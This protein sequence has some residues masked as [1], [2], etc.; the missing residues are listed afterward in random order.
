[1]NGSLSALDSTLLKQQILLEAATSPKIYA[2]VLSCLPQSGEIGQLL[3]RAKADH[4][5]VLLHR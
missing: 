5:V 2:E 3:P 4:S 1:M